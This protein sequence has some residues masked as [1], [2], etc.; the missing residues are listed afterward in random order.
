MLPRVPFLVRLSIAHV[1]G[2]LETSPKWDLRTTLIV[3]F[4]RSLLTSDTPTTISHQQKITLRDPGI[5][6]PIWV[7]S[8]V[9][10]K[11]QINDNA[12][13]TFLNAID[14]RKERAAQYDVPNSEDMYAEWTGYRAGTTKKTRHEK[15]I[16]DAARYQRLIADTKNDT[17][18]LYMHGGGLYLM[19]VAVSFPMIVPGFIAK[20]V[21]KSHRPV[22]SDLARISGGRCLNIRYRLAPRYPF[23]A[24]LLDCFVAYL[25]LLCPPPGSLHDPVPAPKIVFAGDSAGGNL[26]CALLQFLLELHRSTPAG[27]V[28]KVQYLGRE[29][30]IPL[31]AGVACSSAWLDLTRTMPSIKTNHKYDFLPLP[32]DS[33]LHETFPPCALWPAES[34]REDLYC[35]GTLLMHPFVS[36][37]ATTTEDWTNSPPVFLFYGEEMLTDEGKY[38]ARK[39]SK[40]GTSVQWEEF[41]GMPH[42]FPM[43]LKGSKVSKIGMELWG[44]FVAKVASGEAIETRGTFYQAKHWTPKKIDVTSLGDLSDDEI[45]KK[46][47]QEVSVREGYLKCASEKDGSKT[48]RA[49]L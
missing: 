18:V 26:A 43:L 10:S 30:E 44:N 32:S 14:S 35:D 12:F 4:I 47:T 13:P 23:P 19:D 1:L 27:Q 38:F 33:S 17:V 15:G 20:I 24:A 7:S 21:F 2:R 25:F 37:L 29:V 5:S 49:K 8:V 39:L 3:R 11:L 9:V 48:I 36:P 34:R 31:P 41:E 46:M 28:P 42:C 6:G 40:A 16:S 22:C 45:W